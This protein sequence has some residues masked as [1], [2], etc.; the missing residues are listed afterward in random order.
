MCRMHARTG[1]LEPETRWFITPDGYRARAA[2]I[3]KDGR[4]GTILEH[5]EIMAEY[6]GRELLSLETVHHKNGNRSDNRIE[7]LELWSKAQPA[8]QRVSDKIAYAKEILALYGDNEA[9]F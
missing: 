4:R 5:R 9:L 3:K 2:T 7:N 6:V 1:G 8:G